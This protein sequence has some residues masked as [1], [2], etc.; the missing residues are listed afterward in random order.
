MVLLEYRD[1]RL[2]PNAWAR[3]LNVSRE[4][5]ELYAESDVID[6]HLD[7]FIWTRLLGYDLLRR[8]GTGPFG[9]RFFGMA[10]LP[11]VLEAGM[12]GSTWVITTNPLRTAR[13]RARAFFRNLARLQVILQSAPSQVQVVRTAADYHQARAAGRHAAFIGVQGGNALEHDLNDL[14]RLPDLAILRVTLVHLYNSRLGTTSAPSGSWRK[15]GLTR[16]GREF[17]QRLDAKRIFVD[18]AHISR[19]GFADAV[20]VHDRSLPLIVTH[21][22]VCGV[23]PHWRN[24]DDDQ[25]RAIAETGGTVGIMYESGFLGGPR[26][27]TRAEYVVD[28][29]DHVVRTIGEDHVSLGSD[30]DGAILPPRDLSTVLDLPRLVHLMLQRGYG[31]EKIRKILG[32]NFLRALAQLRG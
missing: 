29:I 1:L 30:W 27:G 2:D 10:D 22:G 18:L 20:A 8:H 23:R 12:T 11:R 28:H 26:F 7:T 6:L 24:L 15:H 19:P 14:D 3:A 17:V 32:G 4:A 25:L 21:T 16:L 31:V 5:I 9:A 13:G